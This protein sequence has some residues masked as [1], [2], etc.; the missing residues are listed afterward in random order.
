[1]S[2]SVAFAGWVMDQEFYRQQAQCVR[3][4][5]ERADPF[6]RKCLLNLA[7]SYDAK[8]GSP[9]RASRAIDRPLPLPRAVPG[10]GRSGE[11]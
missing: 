7:D 4:L 1:M 5:A 10:Y 2:L 8:G 6:T 3:D 9:S 11:A